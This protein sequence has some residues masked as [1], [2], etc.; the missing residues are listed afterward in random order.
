MH[1]TTASAPY[2]C[3][4]VHQHQEVSSIAFRF[5]GV[6]LLVFT[7][8]NRHCSTEARP[9]RTDQEAHLVGSRQQK[10]G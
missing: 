3:S 7:S 5:F 6:R 9:I 1:S 10:E 2:L 4:K 8:G